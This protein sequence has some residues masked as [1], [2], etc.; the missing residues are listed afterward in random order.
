MFMHSSPGQLQKLLFHTTF[1]Y[2]L[3]FMWINKHKELEL[4]SQ[5]T[6]FLKSDDVDDGDPEEEEE[7]EI[8]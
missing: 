7:D 4:S 2:F 8:N 1:Y 3:N 5:L 6:I